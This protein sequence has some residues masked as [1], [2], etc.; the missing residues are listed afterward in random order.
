[1][2]SSSS[3][4]EIKALRSSEENFLDLSRKAQKKLS[5]L[6][7]TVDLN[8]DQPYEIFSISFLR[9]KVGGAVVLPTNEFFSADLLVWVTLPSY[10]EDA[11]NLIKRIICCFRNNIPGI[12]Y[13]RIK[14]PN[15]TAS[16]DAVRNV[17]SLHAG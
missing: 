7:P 5:E 13:Y 15:C 1:M 16:Y 17:Y 8:A 2:N 9:E 3:R 11:E 12:F 10:M 14:F 6:F 4:I